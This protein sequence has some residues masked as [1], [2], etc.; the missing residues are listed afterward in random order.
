M[1]TLATRRTQR[2]DRWMGP[3]RMLLL[4]RRARRS[5]DL[6]ALLRSVVRGNPNAVGV[7]MRGRHL[8][9]LVE[10]ALVGELL[11]E[12]AGET[13]KGPGM[14]RVKH[15]LGDGLLTSEGAD[16]RR[17]RRLVA[18]AFSPRRLTGYVDQFAERTAAHVAGWADGDTVDMHREMATLTLDIVGHTLLGIDLRE[19][20][21]GIRSALEATLAHFA[22]TRPGFAGGRRNRQVNPAATP[23]EVGVDT[24]SLDA[25]HGLVDEIIEQR[26]GNLSEDR[27]DVVSALLAADGLT[28]AEVHDHVIT[29][30][31]AGHETTANALSWTLHLLGDHP[32]AQRKLHAELDGLG[33]RLPTSADLPAL[34]Y[35]RAV[36][37]EGI[38]RYPP[39][40]M[41][42]RALDSDIE[43][44]G[45]HV[46]AGSMIAVS[47]LL[48]QH[49]PRWFPEPDAFD[50]D[51]W[52][53]E[54]RALVPRHA[55][56][57]FG[58]GPRS[59]VGEQFAWAEAVTALAVIA[60]RFT[61]RTDPGH[62]VR[63]QFRITMRPG[64]GIPMRLRARS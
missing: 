56:L 63:P 35:T 8:L 45:W 13:N 27:G 61:A 51:R 32:D 3:T 38:R 16:H 52:L 57:P 28:D 46:P 59:C 37:S 41:I 2:P 15:L 62:T 14:A 19:R 55:Y 7:R 6:G 50:P 24:A 22:A 33:G 1:T 17:A 39:A 18:P 64:N 25:L 30:L 49:D 11:I 21:P 12:H 10:P 29:L 5:G 9:L 42:G 60:S 53:D 48:M 44:G 34:P 43:I 54:R 31:M 58:S 20:A 4:T 47:P 36:V 26:R 40:W 23:A